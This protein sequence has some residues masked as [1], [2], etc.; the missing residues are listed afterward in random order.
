MSDDELQRLR[1]EL[2]DERERSFHVAMEA[3][4]IKFEMEKLRLQ[5]RPTPI[6]AV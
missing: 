1:Q 6:K 4:A 3:E 5:D 2:S